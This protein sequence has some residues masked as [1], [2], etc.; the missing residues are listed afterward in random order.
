MF[1]LLSALFGSNGLGQVKKLNDQY[2]ETSFYLFLF[3]FDS[4][5]VFTLPEQGIRR[6]EIPLHRTSLRAYYQSLLMIIGPMVLF[7]GLLIAGIQLPFL[8]RISAYAPFAIALLLCACGTYFLYTFGK[9]DPKET[10]RRIVLDEAIGINVL[11]EWLSEKTRMEF[12]VNL[13]A[14]LPTNWKSLI[15][16]QQYDSVLFYKIYAA[17]YYHKEL[18]KCEENE[19]L[20]TLLDKRINKDLY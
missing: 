13:T 2:I 4:Y 18:E 11:P 7:F 1:P 15:S 3:P 8:T 14:Q 10:K 9:S 20:F 17:M 12:F 19:Y 5:F 6:I 16:R